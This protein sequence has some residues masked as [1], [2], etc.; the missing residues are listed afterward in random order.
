MTIDPTPQ[1]PQVPVGDPKALRQLAEYALETFPNIARS[2]IVADHL[3]LLHELQ[4]HQI[5]LKMQNDELELSHSKLQAI[6]DRY[7]NLFD[8][9]PIGHLNLNLSGQ[10]LLS[11]LTFAKLVGI[12]R[13]ELQDRRFGLLVAASDRIAFS[14]FLISVFASD[15]KQIC[16]LKM[17]RNSGAPLFLRLEGIRSVDTQECLLAAIDITERKLIEEWLRQSQKM[18]VIGQLAGGIAHD[19]NNIL[20]VITGYASVLLADTSETDATHRPLKEICSA[21]A[22][23][24][25]LTTQLLAFSRRQDLKPE[26]VDLNAMVIENVTLLKRLIGAR[27]KIDLILEP[28]LDRVWAERG[29]VAQILMNLVINARD[30]IEGDGTI[31]IQTRNAKL[32]EVRVPTSSTIHS[33]DFALLTVSDNGC[34]MTEEVKSKIFEP[35][36]TTKPEGSGTGIGLTTVYSV[37]KRSGGHIQVSSDPG[38]GTVFQ[39]YLPQLKHPSPSSLPLND[40]SANSIGRMKQVAGEIILL[41]DDDDAVRHLT[42]SILTAA[43]YSVLMA[44]NGNEA[45]EIASNPKL[46]IDL[47]LS[48]VVMPGLNGP[49]L[50]ELVRQTRPEI[51]M[52]MMSGYIKD[53]SL[54]SGMSQEELVFIQKPFLPKE[55]LAT[56]A[57]ELQRTNGN[58]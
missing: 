44:C 36:F 57:A 32:S 24:A 34:G 4:V 28:A 21:S 54:R 50:A 9:A 43:G 27:C 37:V 40:S 15:L 35:F 48:D 2:P 53:S 10:I 12:E 33:D 38:A 5:E 45:L 1:V 18:E 26:S 8:F 41:V 20:T 46:A 17:E 56:I 39:V 51:K 25:Y 29:Q 16:E 13:A 58:R 14:D 55:L 52:V 6:L 11:N 19:F 42:Q 23:A 7:T 30:A 3:A 49:K 31:S 47:M 22:H